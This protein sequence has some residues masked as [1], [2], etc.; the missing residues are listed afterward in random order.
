[1]KTRL[2]L[3]ITLATLTPLLAQ[4]P[5]P[6]PSVTMKGIEIT[7]EAGTFLLAPTGLS[8]GKTDYTGQKPV[9]SLDGDDT[10]LAKFPSGAELRMVVSAADRSVSCSF[11]GVPAEALSILLQMQI[12]ISFAQGGKFSFG[13]KP[14][15]IFPGEKDKQLIGQDTAKQFNLLSPAG[16]GFT[17]MTTQSYAQI[18]DNRVFNNSVFLYIYH[19]QFSAHPGQ[20]TFNFRFETL[21]AALAGN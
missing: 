7:S 3:L 6:V 14:L 21:D 12:P 8:M 10:L 15:E 16:A 20:T 1:M 4:D 13:Q 19:F 5:A 11:S 9:L 17:M 2:S 18:Q